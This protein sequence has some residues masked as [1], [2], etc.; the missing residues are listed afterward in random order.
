MRGICYYKET[1]LIFTDLPRSK[2]ITGF[3]SSFSRRWWCYAIFTICTYNT[4]KHSSLQILFVIRNLIHGEGHLVILFGVVNRILVISQNRQNHLSRHLSTYVVGRYLRTSP[5]IIYNHIVLRFRKN[6]CQAGMWG[7]SCYF[8]WTMPIS[9][10]IQI[11]IFLRYAGTTIFID[12]LHIFHLQGTMDIS[13]DK[14]GLLFE[15]YNLIVS[16]VLLQLL[17]TGHVSVP[18]WR[19]DMPLRFRQCHGDRYFCERFPNSEQCVW[20]KSFHY[21]QWI[22]TK[23]NRSK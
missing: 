16:S 22:S 1:S 4:H 20:I 21:I 12:V 7:W 11:W 15:S 5:C 3:G 14:T 9:Y 13:L 18:I 23:I 2:Q 6:V 10:A 19:T 8:V 17:Q